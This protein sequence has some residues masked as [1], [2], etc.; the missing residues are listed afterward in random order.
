MLQVYCGQ[1]I[2]KKG[3]PDI[4]IKLPDF[5]IGDVRICTIEYKNNFF[6]LYLFVFFSF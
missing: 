4:R 6:I 1:Q 3:Y 5:A 2:Y